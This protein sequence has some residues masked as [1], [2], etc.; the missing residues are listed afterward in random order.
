MYPKAPSL[1]IHVAHWGGSCY[2]PP[3]AQSTAPC[4]EVSQHQMNLWYSLR[5]G[6][7]TTSSSVASWCPGLTLA[8][9]P[10]DTL[11]LLMLRPSLL[12]FPQSIKEPVPC[13]TFLWLYP[14]GQFWV[15]NRSSVQNRHLAFI[16]TAILIPSS[17]EMEG[18]GGWLT[19]F[20]FIAHRLSY[21]ELSNLTVASS[22]GTLESESPGQK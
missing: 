13:Q 6:S 18:K 10:T 9:F 2:S 3:T 8:S 5:Y 21:P 11:S 1:C 22:L 16:C 7:T 20:P 4:S 14:M 12:L 19:K 17:D 15:K